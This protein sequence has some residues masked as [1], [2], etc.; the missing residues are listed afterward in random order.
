MTCW[1]VQG[2]VQRWEELPEAT[3]AR[4]TSS[5]RGL[6]RA[7]FVFMPPWLRGT[8]FPPSTWIGVGSV[9]IACVARSHSSEISMA[10]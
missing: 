2:P 3:G 4:A 7:A 1:G 6:L 8:M 5:E 10:A 9:T